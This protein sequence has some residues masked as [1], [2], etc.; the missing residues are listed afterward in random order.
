MRQHQRFQRHDNNG[1]KTNKNASGDK[2]NSSSVNS[3]TMSTTKEHE[4][5]NAARHDPPAGHSFN[6]RP[7]S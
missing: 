5:R 4:A 1:R 3:E 7:S 2:N 6:K